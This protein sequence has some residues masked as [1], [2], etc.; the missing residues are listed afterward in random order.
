MDILPSLFMIV[1][2]CAV[3][4]VTLYVLSL[5]SRFVKAHERIANALESKSGSQK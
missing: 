3:I 5:A 2:P 4:G 1:Y